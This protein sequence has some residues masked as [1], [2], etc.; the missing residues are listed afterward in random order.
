VLPQIIAEM[1][2]GGLS[3]ADAAAR[4]QELTEQIKSDLG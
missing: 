4:A 2:N 1:I 3:A